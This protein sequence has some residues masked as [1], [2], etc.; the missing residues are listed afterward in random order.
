[1]LAA[2]CDRYGP[3]EVVRLIE[4]PVPRPSA[5]E[6]LIRCHAVTV[7]TADARVR[8]MRMPSPVMAVVGRAVFGFRGPRCRVLGTDLAGVV[9]EVGAGVSRFGVGDRVVAAV[10][11]RFRT[12]AEFAIVR[13]SWVVSKIPDRLTFEDAVAVPFGGFTATYYLRDLGRVS[14]GQRVLIVGAAGA[15]GTAAVQV[16]RQMGANVT[17]V[18]RADNAELVRSLGADHVID[19]TREDFRLRS[20]RFD[21]I[22]DTVGVTRFRECRQ[23]LT[24]RGLF[25]PAVMR[26]AELGQGLASVLS[27]GRRVRGGMAKESQ[28]DLD[29]LLRRVESGAYRPV[30]S[31][32]LG[33]E[34]VV[35]AHRI[36]DSG[37]KVGNVVLRCAGAGN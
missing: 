25:L 36:V 13:S 6:V 3:P 18:C 8:A 26:M 20:E 15:V 24:D 16:A 21:I 11:A 7:S 14:A 9:Q 29:E 4:T 31:R 33:L 17:G 30:V 34:Q 28:Q 10:G 5:G 2:V 27:R 22:F 12:H 32:V 35:E 1:M 19:R 37:T 23:L